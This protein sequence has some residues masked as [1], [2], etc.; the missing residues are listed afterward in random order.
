M[1]LIRSPFASGK[2][3]A[4]RQLALEHDRVDL[5]GVL[6]E[7]RPEL[8]ERVR[9][10]DAVHRRQLAVELEDEVHVQAHG[11]ARGRGHVAGTLDEARQRLV[12]VAGL[13]RVELERR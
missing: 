11:L 13:E 4:L 10:R 8:G 2:R 6:D 3:E 1:V 7:Q 12:L 9:D 5:D